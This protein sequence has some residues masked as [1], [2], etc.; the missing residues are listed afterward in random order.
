M[1]HRLLTSFLVASLLAALSST[2]L[3]TT[4]W[5]VN[6]VSGSDSNDC[7]SVATPCK[8]VGHVISLATSGDSIRVAAATYK[9]NL[10]IG[11]SLQILGSGAKTTILDG[12]GGGRVVTIFSSTAHVTLSGV[13]ITHG[14]SAGSGGGI[15]NRGTLTL[16]AST[17]SGNLVGLG[18]VCFQ[19]CSTA[20]GGIW[21]AAGS[22]STIKNSTVSGNEVELICQTASCSTKGGGIYNMGSLSLTNSTVSGNV[23]FRG[24]H[25]GAGIYNGGIAKISNSTIAGNMDGPAGGS[26]GGIYDLNGATLQ[27]S[28]VANNSDGNCNRTI[29]SDG[30]NLSSDTTCNFGS[31]GDLNSTDPM[32][33]P[34]QY[35]GGQTQTM[36]LPSGSPAV[37]AGNPTG[38]TDGFGHLLKTDQR[39]KAR[40]D[41]EDT[42]GCDMGA[43]ELQSH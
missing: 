32:L 34:L 16:V 13:T 36:S 4:T 43:Y 29:N 26:G 39:G 2:A 19:T 15:F 21:S 28:I 9:E 6:G 23:L 38:C 35:N 33:G 40:P 42:G 30:Y 31:A 22:H 24:L 27:N 20:G 5:Y 11:T 18:T 1:K 17:L 7:N 25:E 8:T 10:T 41:P 37:D 14:F 12:G 3:A